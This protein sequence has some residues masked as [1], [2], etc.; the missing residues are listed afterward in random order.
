MCNYL[1]TVLVTKNLDLSDSDGWQLVSGFKKR[2]RLG[3]ADRDRVLA[4]R[5]ILN[6]G[7]PPYERVNASSNNSMWQ[8]E[9]PARNAD[10]V[11]EIMAQAD[12]P[13][14]GGIPDTGL[15]SITINLSID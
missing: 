10:G 3:F 9:Y 4:L 12:I 11:A 8:W 2:I 13:W 14:Q 5:D 7:Q 6:S 15:C 1:L